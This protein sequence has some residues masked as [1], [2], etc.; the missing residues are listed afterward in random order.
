LAEDK[1]QDMTGRVACIAISVVGSAVAS[2]ALAQHPATSPVVAVGQRPLA[3]VDPRLAE[4]GWLVVE[5]GGGFA[6]DREIPAV[7]L[8]GDVLRVPELTLRLNVA[9]R[10]ELRVDTGYEILLVRDRREAPLSDELDYDGE[11]SSDI[12]DPV[13]S[14]LVRVRDESARAPALGLKIATRL[15]VASNQSGLGLDTTDFFL[16][17]LGAKDA[18]GLRWVANVGLG[19]LEVP[20]A[21][22][23]QNDVLT[24]GFSVSRAVGSRLAFGAGV[25]G[26]VDLSGQV[27][28][29]TEDT[30]LARLGGRFG[31]GATTIDAAI[32]IGLADV[33]APIGVTVGVTRA[34]RLFDGG[35]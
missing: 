20:T 22:T 19:I 27:H 11:S 18:A 26:H 2:A 29:G 4:P 28:P 21:V 35:Q 30:S 6:H 1:I 24:Y 12:R 32:L 14:T 8:R 3:T 23:S 31:A 34:F 33:D 5:I 10:V 16:A 17:L 13:V 25:D 7:G 15:P 9:R